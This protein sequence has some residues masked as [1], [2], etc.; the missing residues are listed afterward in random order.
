MKS[1]NQNGPK[2]WYQENNLP[3][4]DKLKLCKDFVVNHYKT[5]SIVLGGLF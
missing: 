4:I 1:L 3:M 5:I 2:F